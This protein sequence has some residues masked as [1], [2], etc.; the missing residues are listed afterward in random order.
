MSMITGFT[1]PSATVAGL[2]SAAAAAGAGPFGQPTLYRGSV[3]VPMLWTCSEQCGLLVEIVILYGGRS[4]RHL[5]TIVRVTYPG[6]QHRRYVETNRLCCP[7]AYH[8]HRV[9]GHLQDTVSSSQPTHRTS[10]TMS[11][12]VTDVAG[13]T[14]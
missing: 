6:D 2:I 7:R 10:Q 13:K 5:R 4:G 9:G 12:I 3:E 11:E 14:V 8:C 1:Q